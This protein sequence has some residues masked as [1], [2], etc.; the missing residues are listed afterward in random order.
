MALRAKRPCLVASCAHY[1]SNK[2]Y[3][4]SHQSKIQAADQARGNSHQRDYDHQWR[5]ARLEYLAANQLCCSCSKRGYVVPADITVHITPPKDNQ[6]LFW[7]MNNWQA[8]CNA[9]NETNIRASGVDQTE[10]KI[11]KPISSNARFYGAMNYET[12]AT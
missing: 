7:D 5:K 3:C 8:L 11:P 4:E 1:A 10:Y 9:C 2:G 12:K 6:I